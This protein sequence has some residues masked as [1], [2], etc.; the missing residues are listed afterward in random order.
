[1][2]EKIKYGDCSVCGGEVVPKR[3][4][5][6]VSRGGRLVAIVREVPAGVC[7]QCGERYFKADVVKHLEVMLPQVKRGSRTVNIPVANYAAA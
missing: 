4:E 3:V 6:A 7:R 1:M 5:K 2:T